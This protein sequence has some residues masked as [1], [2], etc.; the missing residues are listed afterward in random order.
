MSSSA[1]ANVTAFA[2]RRLGLAT[3][4]RIVHRHGGRIWAEATPELDPMVDVRKVAR[5]LLETAVYV[6]GMDA[7]GP[8]LSAGWQRVRAL[9]DRDPALCAA[10]A[11]LWL[12]TLVPL[13]VPRF[14]PL[15]DLPNHL[16]AISI[17]HRYHDPSWRYSEYYDLYLPPVPYWGYFFPVHVMAYVFD[18]EVANK[19]Y[20]SAYA[21]ALPVGWALLAARM[22]RSPWLATFT[23]PFVFNMNFMFGFISCCAGMAMLP[24]AICALDVFLEKPTLRRGAGLL[25]VV[26]LLYF[27]HVL[28]WLYFGVAAT[29]LLFCHGWHP[30]RMLVAAG[31]M[32]PSVLVALVG[33]HEASAS[34]RTAVQGGGVRFGATW[35]TMQSLLEEIPDRLITNWQSDDR[36]RWFALLLGALWLLL[37]LGSPASAAG[38][39]RPR[40]GYPWRLE[41]LFF[42][43]ALAVFVLPVYQKRPVDL[44]MVGGRFVSL[45]AMFA[46]LL[47]RGVITGDRKLLMLPVVAA[48]L[49]YPIALNWHWMRFDARA[50]GL[51]RLMVN[52]PRGSSTLTLVLGDYGDPDADP[53]AVPYVQ[54]HSYAQFYGGGYDPWAPST[55]FP[56]VARQDKKLP[57]PTWKRP[58]TFR[59]AEHGAHYDYVLTFAEPTDHNLFGASDIPRA[60]LIAKDGDWR[61]YQM[62]KEP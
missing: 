11:A 10:F 51:R 8:L 29:F 7:P 50:A 60:P 12:C 40:S 34:G 30:R 13:W 17:W 4:Q 59:M 55:G 47:P 54:F 6:S 42:L 41:V 39:G 36:G 52:V 5:D 45:A 56:M 61:L 26:M 1:R 28:P 24:Y 15:L 31:L 58:R 9:I 19:I 53:Q 14:L 23:W 44:W 62:L 25:V 27:T 3:V 35:E 57:S 46:A 16:D 2:E 37:A 49:W 20:L 22:G 33:F 18:V 43:A 32:L 21:L 38:E 48:C